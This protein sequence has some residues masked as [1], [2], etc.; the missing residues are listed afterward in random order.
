MLHTRDYFKKITN[1]AF[2]GVALHI[3]SK[4]FRPCRTVGVAIVL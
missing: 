4:R 3:I 2:D 1:F